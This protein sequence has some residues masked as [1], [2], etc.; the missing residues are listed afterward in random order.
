MILVSNRCT[1]RHLKLCPRCGEVKPL[2]EF[3][4]NARRP[5]GVHS[6]CKSCRRIYDHERY[7]RIHGREIAYVPL[8]SERGRRKWLR[9]LKE[10]KPCVDCGKVF[11]PEVMQWDHRIGTEKLFE[12]SAGFA[13]WTREAVLDEIAKCDLVCTNCHIVRTFTRAEWG[14]KWLSETAAEYRVAA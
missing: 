6:I 3:S 7:E 8:R 14:H 1:I 13:Q 5:D 4:K 2:S 12:I 10:G 9:S 11:A